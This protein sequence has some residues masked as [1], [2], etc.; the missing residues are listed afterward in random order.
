MKLY[1]LIAALFLAVFS[2]IQADSDTRL[3]K[4]PDGMT[5][6]H[7]RAAYILLHIWD[8]PENL[9]TPEKAEQ[10]ISDFLSVADADIASQD[11]YTTAVDTLMAK[12]NA[13]G[14]DILTIAAKYTSYPDAPFFD[15]ELYLTFI[16]AALATPTLLESTPGLKDRLQYDRACILKNRIGTKAAS[17]IVELPSG[18]KT[19][20]DSLFKSPLNLLVLFDPDCDHCR[21]MLAGLSASTSLAQ[22]VDNKS[23]SVTTV[24]IDALDSPGTLSIPTAEGWN[25]VSDRTGIMDNELYELPVMPSVYVIDNNGVVVN[26]NLVKFSTV[27]SALGLSE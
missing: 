3:P 14:I 23:I 2:S 24:W 15:D 26:K 10:A 1:R 6:P 9:S 27:I 13:A 5:A 17:F 21:D 20:V 25:V 16:D 19:P 8:F 18:E 4:L 11:A 12:A 7:E 22:A